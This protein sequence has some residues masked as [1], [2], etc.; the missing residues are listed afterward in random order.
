[1]R[2]SSMPAQEAFWRFLGRFAKSGPKLIAIFFGPTSAASARMLPLNSASGDDRRGLMSSHTMMAFDA[3]LS[4]IRSQVIDMGGRVR[5]AV[6]NGIMALAERDLDLAPSLIGLDAEIDSM[7]REV[8]TKAIETIAR[9]QPL[10]VDLR[11]LVSAFHIV[12]DLERIGDLGK[13]ICK[14]VL[15]MDAAPAAK[16][17]RGIKRVSIPVL[18]QLGL[19]LDSYAERDAAKALSVWSSDKEIDP[20]HGALLRGLMT[21][22]LEDPRNIVFCAHL[23]FCS[24][25]LERMGDHTTNIAESVHYMVTGSRLT[26]DRPKGED[27]SFLRLRRSVAGRQSSSRA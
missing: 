24:K 15:I 1:M 10:A 11:E 16:L 12:N 17:L 13:N 7:Q 6:E 9:R 21:H 22:M 2:V 3:D 18:N 26:G 19:V 20:A 5:T 25:N 23:L 8:E 14:R 27:L 4:A